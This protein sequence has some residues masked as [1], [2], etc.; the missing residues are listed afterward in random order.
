MKG[1]LVHRSSQNH[2]VTW[3]EPVVI[4]QGMNNFPIQYGGLYSRGDTVYLLTAAGDMGPDTQPLDFRRSDDNGLTWSKPIRISVPGQ[5]I[6]RA[7]IVANGDSVHV[8]GAGITRGQKVHGTW[9][10]R[11]IDRG[12]TWEPGRKLSEYGA[13]TIA[14]DGEFLHVP[15]TRVFGGV[16][17]GA[18]LY[19]RS[20]DNGETWHDPIDIGEKSV[21]CSRQARVQVASTDGRVLVVWQR[22]GEYTGAAVPAERFGCNRSEDGGKTWEGAK[23]LSIQ[24]PKAGG[25]PHIWMVAGG[26]THLA[27]VHGAYD[28]LNTPV[29]YRFSPD[30]GNNWGKVETAINTSKK[31]QP[32]S[33][34][35]DANAVHIIAEPGAGIYAHRAVPAILC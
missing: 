34:V 29:G 9:Y 10:F 27:W 3:S 8:A 5:E 28:E 16:G 18:T 31:N 30:Y 15:Y 35:A 17:G 4:A 21:R 22:E 25:H 1:A 14:V 33:I 19:G 7:R 32:H 11:S 6:R 2:G 24:P 20:T 26:A 23:V 13:Q 12:N